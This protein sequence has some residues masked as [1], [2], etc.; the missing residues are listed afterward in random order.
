MPIDT[1]FP[2]AFATKTPPHAPAPDMKPFER[3]HSTL[4]QADALAD[5]VCALVGRLA[6]QVPEK[7]S[8]SGHLSDGVLFGLAG[9][10]DVTNARINRA[11]DELARL[12]KFL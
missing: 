5:A 11:F 4:A 1:T 12:E 9:H 10:A 8:D 2:T 7:V 3:V 6:G